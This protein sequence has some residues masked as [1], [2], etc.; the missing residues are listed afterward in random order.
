ME[1]SR[2]RQDIKMEIYGNRADR[3]CIESVSA[4]LRAV[5]EE[6]QRIRQQLSRLPRKT[7]AQVHQLRGKKLMVLES[8]DPRSAGMYAQRA[9]LEMLQ[10]ECIYKQMIYETTIR[11]LTAGLDVGRAILYPLSSHMAVAGKVVV[12]VGGHRRDAPLAIEDITEQ[13]I[14][15]LKKSLSDKEKRTRRWR[16]ACARHGLHQWYTCY[17]TPEEASELVRRL[18]ALRA[19]IGL[20]AAVVALGVSDLVPG[21]KI[22]TDALDSASELYAIRGE[23]DWEFANTISNRELDIVNELLAARTEGVPAGDLPRKA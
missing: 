14:K 13:F 6:K 19:E 9:E 11:S 15:Q 7:G 17:L 21:Q 1:A 22:Y 10:M 8:A 20:S 2:G 16:E 3:E 5:T 18:N 4:K 23:S 12:D